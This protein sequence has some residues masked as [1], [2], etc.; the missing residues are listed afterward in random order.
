M[1][2]S[3]SAPYSRRRDDNSKNNQLREYSRRSNDR[4]PTDNNPY[5]R[6]SR[7]DLQYRDRGRER[8]V[9]TNDTGATRTTGNELPR[10]DSIREA[11]RERTG[12]DRGTT[13]EDRP[14]DRTSYESSRGPAREDRP[15]DNIP[16]GPTR[17]RT[18]EGEFRDSSRGFKR[19]AYG[20][21]YRPKQPR[22]DDRTRYQPRSDRYDNGNSR[23][24]PVNHDRYQPKKP[25]QSPE[26]ELASISSRLS[27]LESVGQL[28]QIK[29]IDSRW[30][31]KPKG[32]EQ[33]SAQRAKLSG[34]FPL[35]GFPRPV[36]FTKLEGLIKDRLSSNDDILVEHSKIDPI[37]SRDAKTLIIKNDLL[38]IDYLKLVE[39]FNDYLKVIDL[40]STSE[41]NNIHTK[42]KTK[43]DKSLIIEFNNS[44]C[45]TIIYS[46]NEMEL[47]FNAYKQ[48]H[49]TNQDEKFKLLISR[50]REYLVQNVTSTEPNIVVDN[51][52]KMSLIVS[53]NVSQEELYDQLTK[54]VHSIK[55]MQFLTQRRSTNSLGLVFIEFEVDMNDPIDK[56][57]SQLSKYLTK[58]KQISNVQQAFFSCIIPPTT[59][60]IQD[61]LIEYNTLPRLVRNEFVSAH[62][63]SKVI[64]LLNCITL[65]DLINDDN[66]KFI[67][68]DIKQQALKFG[69]VVS[70]KIPRPEHNVIN[71]VET[72]RGLG[73]VFIEFESYDIALTAILGLAGKS[74]NDRI[75]LGSFYDY[76]D[77]KH[78][79]L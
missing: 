12:Y 75:V 62:S 3:G 63:K 36:D 30:G 59:A 24:Q 55:S 26:D 53:P 22:Y 64:Q 16:R 14:R 23:E 10:G 31:V 60:N 1:S 7:D 4:R 15:R 70:I 45:A 40:N 41:T 21:S 13:R 38:T 44:E 28:S 42:R 50:P 25:E 54:D 11:R 56:Q 35:P 67:Q 77:Y 34:L 47:L 18:Y 48:E 20:D 19:E 2:S 69:N 5:S 27:E 52:R 39:F 65:S 74:Y 46:L 58:I 66:F 29:V 32:F 43:D 76:E 71:L 6:R 79:L 72:R 8:T 73:K 51:P 37:D 33:V 61:C 57:I 9:G 49:I 68:Q 78:G 17:E